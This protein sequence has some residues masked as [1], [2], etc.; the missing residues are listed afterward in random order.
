[1]ELTWPTLTGQ[2]SQ[3]R[4]VK[5]PFAQIFAIASLDIGC[6]CCQSVELYKVHIHVFAGD[7]Q[8]EVGFVRL[9]M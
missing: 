1:V 4:P 7:E 5:T 8:T 6:R 3:T 9:P 2:V